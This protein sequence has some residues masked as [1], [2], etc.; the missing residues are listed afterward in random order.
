MTSTDIRAERRLGIGGSD[1]AAICGISQ[2]KSPLDVWREKVLDDAVTETEAMRWGRR[3]EPVVLAAYAEETGA[4][5][6]PVEPMRDGIFSARPDALAE[7]D[8]AVRVVEAKTTRHGDAWG[9]PGTDD[10]PD[11]YQAQGQWYL[12][13]L[14]LAVVDFPVLIAGSDFRVYRSLRHQKIVDM[15]EREAERFWREHVETLVPPAPRDSAE[16]AALWRAVTGSS[17]DLSPAVL[18]AL[19]DIET[20]KAEIKGLEK[21]L[22]RAKFEVQTFLGANE[23]GIDDAGNVRVTWKNQTARRL[24][25]DRIKAEA[26]D[27]YQTYGKDV[28]SRVLR[29]VTPKTRRPVRD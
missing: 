16:A 2:W 5:M 19:D 21:R 24:D 15:L 11:E 8:G 28:E 12:A 17:V 18:A 10:V 23:S 25:T 9:T 20:W 29:T 7:L 26:P 14:K 4:T 1:V 6:L 3:L 27:L 22:E 13:R